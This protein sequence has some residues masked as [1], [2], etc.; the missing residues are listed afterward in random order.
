MCDLFNPSWAQNVTALFFWT[1][2]VHYLAICAVKI[3][4]EKVF[5]LVCVM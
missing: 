3:N 4:S 1:Q 5:C 2:I